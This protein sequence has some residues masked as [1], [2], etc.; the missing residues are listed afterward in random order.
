MSHDRVPR[1]TVVMGWATGLALLLVVSIVL[2]SEVGAARSGA[3]ET[4]TSTP[5]P[6]VS[7]AGWS[8]Y[9]NRPYG[10]S[11]RYPTYAQFGE[12]GQDSAR[13]AALWQA[14]YMR[15]PRV[16]VE[17]ISH[18]NPGDLTPRDFVESQ[19]TALQQTNVTGLRISDHD[20]IQFDFVETR[21]DG[22]GTAIPTRALLVAHDG[23]I[24]EFWVRPLSDGGPLASPDS[25][26]TQTF[27]SL[28][29]HHNGLSEDYSVFLAMLSSLTFTQ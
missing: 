2:Y 29:E 17:I 25:G 22:T 27:E 21:S 28:L 11:L 8:V 13:S 14:V 6:G 7:T 10:Y 3:Q 9:T 12:A 19:Y 23:K 15:L 16:Y 1:A 4:E 5:A 20:A 18:E 24:L 26:D